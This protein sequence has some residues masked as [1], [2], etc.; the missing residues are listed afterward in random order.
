MKP[1]SSLSR[2]IRSS[3]TSQA[4]QNQDLLVKEQN[5]YYEIWN[6]LT[7]DEQYVLYDLT[8]DGLVNTRNLPIIHRL[9]KKG[10]ISDNENTFTAHG[11]SFISSLD[12]F[13]E[14]FSHFIDKLAETENLKKLEEEIN[15]TGTWHKYRTPLLITLT[16]I[17]LFVFITQQQTYGEVI[18][19]LGS[20]AASLPLILRLMNTFFTNR[21]ANKA[22]AA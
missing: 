8:H 9:Y 20:I 16:G 22:T 14:R 10:L 15:A 5:I 7:P 1:D 3:S 6:S 12:I 2:K 17:L 4:E 18:G 13:N 21:S 11:D 19:V